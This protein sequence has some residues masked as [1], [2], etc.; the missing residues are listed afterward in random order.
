[1]NLE[2]SFCLFIYFKFEIL[3]NKHFQNFF[4]EHKKN[5]L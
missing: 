1:M 3:I 5:N 4:F 2:F